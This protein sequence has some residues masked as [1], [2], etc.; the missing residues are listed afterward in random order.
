[1]GADRDDRDVKVARAFAAVHGSTADGVEA[2]ER[3]A[4][5]MTEHARRALQNNSVRTVV[6]ASLAVVGA[7]AV[8]REFLRRR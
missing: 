8:L 6:T 3:G 4:M 1:M 2:V 5:H 7:G